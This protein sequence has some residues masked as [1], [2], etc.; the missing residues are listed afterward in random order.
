MIQ[1]S[2]YLLYRVTGALRLNLRSF[3]F[4]I[5]YWLKKTSISYYPNGIF[6]ESKLQNKEE[7]IRIYTPMIMQ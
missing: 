1:V 7:E 2:W 4:E 6:A 5:K 3:R